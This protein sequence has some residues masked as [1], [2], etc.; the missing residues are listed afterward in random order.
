MNIGIE[1]AKKMA[2]LIEF[3]KKNKVGTYLESRFEY[4]N[5]RSKVKNVA[6]YDWKLRIKKGRK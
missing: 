2:E 6:C 5:E 1:I 3:C 4:T